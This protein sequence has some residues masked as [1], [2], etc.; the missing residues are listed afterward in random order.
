M[1]GTAIEYYKD[2]LYIV[3]NN[4]MPTGHHQSKA[5]PFSLGSYC[6]IT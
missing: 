6:L 4:M 1:G 2:N 3:H 5:V